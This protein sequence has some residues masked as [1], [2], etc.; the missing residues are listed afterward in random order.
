MDSVLSSQVTTTGYFSMFGGTTELFRLRQV[1]TSAHWIAEYWDGAAWASVGSTI[2]SPLAS[3]ANRYDIRFN[4]ANS[5]GEFTIYVNGLEVATF[6]GDTLTTA[7]TTIS[8][9][10]FTS[11]STSGVIGQTQSIVWGGIVFDSADTRNIV[12]DE[13][14][15]NATGAETGWTNDEP[16]IDDRYGSPNI[17]D[18]I[19][20]SAD[21]QTETFIF[22]P[23]QGAVAGNNVDGVYLV[24]SARAQTTPGLHIRGISR[25]SGVNYESDNAVQ[26]PSDAWREFILE[27]DLNPATA[28]EWVNP[29]AV[30]AAQWGVR[31][32][33]TP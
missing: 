2:T 12:F 22:N 11:P 33:A 32:K 25:I 18:F 24:I 30:D 31:V 19:V 10:R 16:A 17:A 28:A 13:T 1:N 26:P 14:I 23:A 21:G 29:A 9:I 5:G 8:K 20:G 27:F 7:D 3:V 4:L 15:A 6:S